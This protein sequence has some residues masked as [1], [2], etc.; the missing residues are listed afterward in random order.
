MV[1]SLAK[2]LLEGILYLHTHGLCHNDLQAS[3]ILIAPGNKVK[4]ADFGSSHRLRFPAPSTGDSSATLS[5]LESNSL[6]QADMWSVGILM[7]FML[8]GQSPHNDLSPLSSRTRSLGSSNLT[9]S[10]GSKRELLFPTTSTK[11][12]RLA[13]QLISGL[14]HV[15]PSIRFTAAEALAHPWFQDAPTSTV[16]SSHK[17][18]SSGMFAKSREVESSSATVNKKK[19]GLTNLLL[20][21]RRGATRSSP[22]VGGA[23]G[24]ARKTTRD[25]ADLTESS[26]ESASSPGEENLRVTLNRPKLVGSQPKG[27]QQRS[28]GRGF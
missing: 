23:G 5:F 26:V 28:R 3:N 18:T 20:R 22:I 21:G 19:N 12:S 14:I 16:S 7:Y 4:I 27:S 17:A 24:L 15:D 6:A 2:S 13:K 9:S 1:K 8:F 10:G 11:V 25:S